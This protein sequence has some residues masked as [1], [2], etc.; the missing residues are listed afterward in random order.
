MISWKRNKTQFPYL[1][2]GD[3]TMTTSSK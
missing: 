3:R 2:A 1:E